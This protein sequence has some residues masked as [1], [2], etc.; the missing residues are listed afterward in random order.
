MDSLAGQPIRR[1]PSMLSLFPVK[2]LFEL[3]MEL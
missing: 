2:D 1:S 3:E